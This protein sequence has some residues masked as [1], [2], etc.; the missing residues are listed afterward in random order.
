[1]ELMERIKTMTREQV[2]HW[3]VD[4]VTHVSPDNFMRLSLMASYL[5]GGEDAGSA[6][7]A[8]IDSLKLGEDGQATKM[9]RRVM[10]ELSPHCLKA[11]SRN[12]FVNGLL[13]S[14]AMRDE[15]AQ[16]HGF[17]PP[18]TVLISPTMQCNLQ[19]KGCYSGKYIRSQ[20]L[21]YDL[22]D[23]IVGEACDMGS[24]FI[25]LSG[26]EPL[27][28]KGDLFRLVGKYS[29]MYFMFYTN[30]TLID[31]SVADRL[32][33]LGNAGAIMS[34][35]GFEEATDARRGRGVFKKVMDAM[36]RLRERGVAFG[37]S[38]TVTRHNIEQLTSDAF[39]EHIYNKGVM[40]CWLF[41]FLPV[42]KDPD[43]SLMPTP[44]QREYLRQRGSQLRAKYPIFIADFWNDAPHVGGCIAGG[45]NYIHINA[46]G[47]VEPCVFTHFAVDKIHDKSLLEV[48][49]SDFFR[50]I[51]SKQPYSENLLTPCMIIDNPDV[52][53]EVVHSC[54]AYPTHD[55]AEDVLMKIKNE[56]DDYGRRIRALEDPIWEREKAE[57]GYGDIPVKGV[58]AAHGS[59]VPAGL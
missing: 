16:K 33:S 30:G 42:G 39:F 1:M 43:V 32:H 22:M 45:R 9:F 31:E 57:Y 50:T 53:R 48:L 36:D 51:R 54:N 2:G 6:V 44:E 15:F 35:E 4:L 18:F 5:I 34:L 49:Q 26:G 10:T 24:L 52:Y 13:R 40:V 19:C 29:D 55:G 8:V 37:T 23:R 25:V 7:D 3:M 41:L 46:N 56:L 27:T 12:L 28:R 21:S 17:A 20:G 14:S 58:P 47:D 59:Q 11:V 38:L